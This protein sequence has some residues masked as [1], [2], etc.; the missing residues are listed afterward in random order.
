MGDIGTAYVRVAPNMQGIQGKI[1]SGFK[2]SGTAFANQFGGEVS[3]RSAVIA[4]AIAGVAAAAVNKGMSLI[5]NSIGTAI[6]R[7]DTLANASKTFEYMGFKADDAATATKAITK[8]ILGLPTPL[9]SAIR[10]MTSLAATY[11]D[12]KLGQKVFT[13][14]NDAILG[15]GGSAEMV[16]N[17]IQQVSQLPLDGPLDAQTWMSLRN[18]GLTPVLVAMGK[19]MGRSVSKLKEDFGS[20]KLTVQDF[21]N[22]LTKID[23]KGGGGLVSLQKIAQNAT[24]GI[25]TGFSNMQTAIARGIANIIQSVGQKNISNAIASI[26]KAFETVLNTVAKAV[27]IIIGDIKGFFDLVSR[28]KDIF[29]PIAAGIGA[30]VVALAAWKVATIAWS[31][32]TKIAT[33]V[34]AGFNAIMAANPIGLVLLA[35]VGLTAG[36]TYFFAKTAVGKKIFADITKVLKP[37]IDGFKA[38]F[39]AFTNGRTTVGGFIGFMETLGIVLKKIWSFVGGQLGSAFKSLISIFKQFGQAIQPIVVAVGNFVKAMLQNKAVVTILKIIGVALLAIVAAPIVVFVATLVA[40]ITILSKVLGF[41][42]RHFTVLKVIMAIVFLPL[43]ASVA[44]VIG[45][46]KLVIATVKLLVNVFTTVFS[47][48]QKIVTTAFGAI[49]TAWNSVLYPVFKIMFIIV[50]T[51]LTVFIRVWAAIALVIVGT[52]AIIAS[53]VW[54]TMQGIWNVVT[55]VWN[56]VYGV[57]SSVIGF[58]TGIIVNAFNFY[59]GIIS[60]VLGAIWTVVSSVWNTIYGFLAKIFGTIK[61]IVV[62][63]WNSIYGTISGIVGNIWNSVSGTFNK[64]VSF[65]AGI[66]GRIIKALGNFGSLLYNSGKDMIQGLLNGAGSLLS[67]I[68]QFFLDKLPGWIQGPFKKALGIHSPSVV[69]AGFG[70]NIVK[71]LAQGVDNNSAIAAKSV[72]NMANDTMAAM[73]SSVV[74]PNMALNYS[75]P[76]GTGAANGN[77]TT[78]TTTIQQVVLGDQSAVKEFF[79]QL[80]QDTINVGMGLTPVQG[81]Q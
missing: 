59:Y 46:V 45:A 30:V 14:L 17:A 61:N 72:N 81:A 60:K 38:L 54:K 9:D 78:N 49:A 76:A 20:G 56:A 64:I 31:A 67:K 7:V 23:T 69:F 39:A 40:G 47:V 62:G 77:T 3:S 19:D 44:I 10:G 68:G 28:N 55:M 65:A 75:S 22:E 52:M 51:I 36:L 71:G 26:G 42:A 33:A 57:I 53:I 24:S 1:A 8:S 66:G 70:K 48:I 29:Y 43:I 5:S 63:A 58:I 80:N 6:K 4:G 79:K 21:V 12:V 16:D 73:T 32:A 11:G 41:L 18:S 15:F 37:M 34:Q 2:G 13:A 35:I 74:D 25:G 50:E 27:P